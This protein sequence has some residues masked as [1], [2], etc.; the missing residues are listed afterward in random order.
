MVKCCI[1]SDIAVNTLLGIVAYECEHV[2]VPVSFPVTAPRL[3]NLWLVVYT[4]VR[5]M[6][7]AGGESNA[8]G[9][10]WRLSLGRATIPAAAGG[11]RAS[12]RPVGTPAT[13][14]GK[15][16]ARTRRKSVVIPSSR[17]PSNRNRGGRGAPFRAHE[18]SI[19]HW[20]CWDALTDWGACS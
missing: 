11:W 7:P 19:Y 5:W 3:G 9:R 6:K 10:H 17:A 16:D 2:L 4:W 15:G 1:R 20:S 12:E 8:G 18:N 14:G 13:N